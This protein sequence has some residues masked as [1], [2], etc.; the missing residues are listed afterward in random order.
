MFRRGLSLSLVF[1][2]A[3]ILSAGCGGDYYK[4]VLLCAAKRNL[5]ELGDERPRVRAD[6]HN[7]KV[8]QK[9]LMF[10]LEDPIQHSH[11]TFVIGQPLAFLLGMDALETKGSGYDFFSQEIRRAIGGYAPLDLALEPDTSEE[12]VYGILH[13]VGPPDTSE[14]RRR[15]Q[16]FLDH[17]S[18]RVRET[19]ALYLMNEYKDW[20]NAPHIL[21]L[22]MCDPDEKVRR[23]IARLIATPY[24]PYPGLGPVLRELAGREK[25]EEIKKYL[26]KAAKQAD[27]WL[28]RVSRQVLEA[29]SLSS[30]MAQGVHGEVK[31]ELRDDKLEDKQ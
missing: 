31:T 28:E 6:A 27:E 11:A 20:H 18:A 5:S 21:R 4:V 12:Q 22:V 8:A 7:L 23:C 1:F 9:L 14:I 2:L 19:A 15:L 29:V 10:Y 24:Q 3:C 17:P 26:L 13:S 30:G 16:K 25:D